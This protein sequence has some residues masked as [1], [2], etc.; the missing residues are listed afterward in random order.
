M[1]ILST[2]SSQDTTWPISRFL[3]RKQFFLPKQY[4]DTAFRCCFY[5]PYSYPKSRFAK[6]TRLIFNYLYMFEKKLFFD[7]PSYKKNSIFATAKNDEAFIEN[8]A[9][10]AQLVE[11]LIC[12]Q[13]VVGSSP[14]IGS[15]HK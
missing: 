14:T 2:A 3:Q 8:Y 15:R 6:F 5:Q 7:V 1:N 12:N 11:Q 13:P 4:D 9:D 10:I